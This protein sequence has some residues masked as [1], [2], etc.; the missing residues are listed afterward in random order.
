M[1]EHRTPMLG[2]AP[3]VWLFCEAYYA[4]RMRRARWE[5]AAVMY[6]TEWAKYDRLL[7]RC[8]QHH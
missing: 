4:C 7:R 3:I 8:M 5:D 1:K 6:Y 2:L